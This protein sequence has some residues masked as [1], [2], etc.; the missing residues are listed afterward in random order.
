MI[1]IK[2]S[3]CGKGFRVDDNK[4]G[5]KGKCPSCGTMIHIPEPDLADEA[6]TD[7]LVV[8][9]IGPSPSAKEEP[10][11]ARA[12]AQPDNSIPHVPEAPA[13]PRERPGKQDGGIWRKLN[14]PML[15]GKTR[16]AN[17]R[18]N[19]GKIERKQCPKCKEGINKGATKCPH[20][21]SKHC[22]SSATMVI[23][24]R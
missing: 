18:K 15:G 3:K 4:A 19:A 5:K 16:K 7:D 21:Q 13:E 14:S 8:E 23:R 6:W 1:E 9:A 22:T 2:C 20:C 12:A 11:K 17:S 24:G 10:V